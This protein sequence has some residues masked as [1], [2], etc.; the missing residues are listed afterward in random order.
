MAAPLVACPS[1]EQPYPMSEL[2][3][4]FDRQVWSADKVAAFLEISKTHFL[5]CVQYAEGFP[6]PLP[7]PPYTVAGRQR[8]MDSRWS[9]AAVA[10][11]VHG[12]STQESR[13]TS[14]SA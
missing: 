7:I 1:S 12:E 13:K 9:A 14:V 8:H 6:A 3:V 10:A 11:W 5:N 4:P 2:E